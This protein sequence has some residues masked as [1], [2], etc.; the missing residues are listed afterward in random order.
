MGNKQGEL[1]IMRHKGKDDI[2]WVTK[3]WWDES[4]QWNIEL[5][6]WTSFQR[7]RQHS[8]GNG[9]APC[10]INDFLFVQRS[11]KIMVI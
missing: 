8:G 2:T 3:T 9:I 6:W 11:T 7:C 4:H 5:D 1:D 10:L